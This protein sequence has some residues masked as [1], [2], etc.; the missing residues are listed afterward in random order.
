[1]FDPTDRRFL[2]PFINCT[3]CGPRYTIIKDIPYDRPFTTMAAFPMCAACNAEYQDPRN[4]RFHAQPNACPECGPHIW[5]HPGG[6]KSKDAL[7]SARAQ[8]REGQIVAI[9]G[10]GGFHLA[11]DATDSS[12]VGALRRRK[13]RGDKPFAL[14]ARDLNEVRKFA[15][16]NEDEAEQLTCRE[17]PIVLLQRKKNSALSPLVS[18]GTALVGFMLPY[19]PLHHLLL[20]DRPL[21]MTSGNLSDE[22]IC[23]ENEEALTRLSSLADSFLLHNRDIHV[24]CDDSVVRLHQKSEVPLR[25]ARGYAPLPV[26]LTRDGATVL[27][28]GAE[29][30]STFCLTK[31][32]YAYISP[33][34]GDMENLETMHAMERG[35]E[36][37]RSIF[38]CEP[39]RL[40]C[41]MHPGYLSTRWAEEFSEANGIPL[42]KVQHHHAHV[43]SLAAEHGLDPAETVIGVAYDGT[44]YGTDRTIWGGEILVAS[45]KSFR[46]A[47]HLKY[48]PMLVAMLQSETLS[49]GPGSLGRS[50]H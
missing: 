34:I 45:S 2:Y 10:I 48:V 25:R 18:P 17:R 3:N 13:N 21:V 37:F 11:C 31:G 20:D 42:F 9:K 24:V 14:M 40:V 1:L 50:R 15:D 8:L 19:S 12:A 49:H 5:L 22:P 6:E 32:S 33:H 44:G 30:K 36:H 35:L 29:L 27:A 39:S 46:R 26:K 47:A 43:A 41:D 4:R 28:V 7:D 23:R 38:R 16:V